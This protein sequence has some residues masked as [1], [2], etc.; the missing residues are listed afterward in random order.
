MLR[1]RGAQSHSRNYQ[2]FMPFRARCTSCPAGASGRIG[3][4][5]EQPAEECELKALRSVTQPAR[6]HRGGSRPTG[7][8]SSGS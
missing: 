3:L 2:E 4:N 1:P 7:G 5:A 6:S 8:Q